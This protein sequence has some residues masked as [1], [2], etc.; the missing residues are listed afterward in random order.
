MAT[1]GKWIDLNNEV[2]QLDENG[3]NKLYKDKEALEEYS[4]YIEKNT[5][6]FDNEVERVRTLTKEGIYDKIFDNVP[7]TIIE[8][9]TKL[10]YSFNFQF[11]SFMAC[12]KFYESYAVT[13][14]DK[15][16]N[17]IFVE[18]YEQHNVRVALYLFQDDYVKA[19]EMLIQ[20]MEQTLQSATPTFLN[21][22]LAKRG[23]LSSCYIFVVDDSTE[24][25][26]FVTNNTKEASRRAGGVSVE[27][28]RIRP[29]GSE[30]NGRP[31]ASKGVLPFA[32]AIEQ[33]VSHFDQGKLNCPL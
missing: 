20:L 28:S 11:Q 25:I 18:D 29:K 27:A 14:Y 23:E 8:E 4:K 26:N 31:N 12:Q 32:K 7:D 30:V 1:Y 16:D 19:R 3:K 6:N 5:R 24:S 21:G 9:M 17:P 13:Q 15:D 22:G 10:A 2:T 33:G